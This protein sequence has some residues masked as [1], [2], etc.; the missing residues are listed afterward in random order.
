MELRGLA[1]L[2]V[3]FALAPATSQAQQ[4][5]G[6]PAEPVTDSAHPQQLG[7]DLRPRPSPTAANV[8]IGARVGG[9]LA[10]SD[11]VP[12]AWLFRFDYEAFLYLAPRGTVGGLFGFLTGW[13]YWHARSGPNNWGFGMPTAFVIGMRAVAVRGLVGFGV[14]AF[15][16]DQV[17]DDTGFGWCAPLALADVGLD[18]HGLTLMADAR[19][20]RRWQ[21]GADDHTQ[22]MFSVMVGSTLEPRYN[23]AFFD[24]PAPGSR[25]ATRR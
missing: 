8:G 9:G 15:T 19:V 14:N 5:A 21:F 13:D 25:H 6:D 20:S 4:A 1:A 17:N 3:G 10:Y 24:G 18:I 16:I 12:D 23:R 22:W 2:V 11:G 7:T